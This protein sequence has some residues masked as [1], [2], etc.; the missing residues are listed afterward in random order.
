MAS[1]YD[2]M[3]VGSRCGR[4]AWSLGRALNDVIS[5]QSVFKA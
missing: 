4:W 2:T 1:G 3:H 5:V